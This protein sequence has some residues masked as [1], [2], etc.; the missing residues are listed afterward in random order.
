MAEKDLKSKQRLRLERF[1]MAV[2]TYIIVGCAELLISRLGLGEMSRAQW[3]IFIVM[4]L[5]GNMVFFLLFVTGRNLRFKDPSMTWA[6]IFYSA[7]WGMVP[8]YAM[9]G[10]R[11]IVLVFYVPA[12]SFG[13]LRLTRRQYSALAGSVLGVYLLL[14][15]LEF[16]QGRQGF[17][18]GYELFL[19]AIFSILLMWLS[20]FGGFVSHIRHRLNVQKEELQKA[21]EEIKLEMEE[22]RLAQ[23]E[24]DRLIVELRAA[25]GKVKTL[26]G[27]LPICASCKKIR[28]DAGYWRQIE[29]Y[30]LEHSDAEFSHSLCPE[31]AKK[32]YPEL[33]IYEN[34]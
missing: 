24:N 25:L 9:P 18:L 13:M 34:G 7:L 6:Q 20:F 30:I 17:R 22:R 19:F 21:H 27:L 4:G 32:L 26:G 10:A 3:V 14:L 8:L 5:G 29:S 15:G 31:C 16:L 33:D 23:E 2:V 11:P 1:G 12:F 28:D